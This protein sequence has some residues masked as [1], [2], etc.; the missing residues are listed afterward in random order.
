MTGYRERWVKFNYNIY[1]VV[2][3][4]IDYYG[5]YGFLLKNYYMNDTYTGERFFYLNMLERKT[6]KFLTEAEIKKHKSKLL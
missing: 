4:C 5:D 2:G 3:Y 6:V 1:K